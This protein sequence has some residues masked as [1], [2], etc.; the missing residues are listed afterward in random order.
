MRTS[1]PTTHTGTNTP[2]TKANLVKDGPYLIYSPTG[3]HYAE[4]NVFVAR[5]KYNASSCMGPFNT[6]LRRNFTVEEYFA[7]MG[8][9]GSPLGILNDK[10][11]LSPPL[12][13]I[14]RKNGF[15]VTREG[16]EAYMELEMDKYY[17]K[18][19]REEAVNR[20]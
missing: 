16:Y 2:F 3:R 9:G 20:V 6:F 8:A 14:C 10:G 5:F 15:P 19:G 13:K 11:Y 18:R 4:D 1:L 12:R 17:A 7:L